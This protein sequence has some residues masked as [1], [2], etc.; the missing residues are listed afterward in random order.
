MFPLLARHFQPTFV[1][2]KQQKNT[3]RELTIPW[4]ILFRDSE[5]SAM[6]SLGVVWRMIGAH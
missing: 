5:R 3:V 2:R 4:K 6:S 1:I